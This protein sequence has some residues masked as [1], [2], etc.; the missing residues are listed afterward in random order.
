[1]SLTKSIRK[2]NTYAI[3]GIIAVLGFNT[4]LANGVNALTITRAADGKTITNLALAAGHAVV[5]LEFEEN[6][7]LFS[8]NTTFGAN[9]FPKH[10][11]GLKFNGRD[12][13]RNEVI[14]S[15]DLERNTFL[16]KLASGQTVLL[17]GLN[18]LVGEKS[19]SGAG[20]KSEDFFGYD[21]LLSGAELEKAPV[22][23]EADF[24]EFAALVAP[25]AAAAV[26]V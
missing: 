4:K 10:Q 19:D 17:G 13:L 2:T 18:G 16:A 24:A 26:V 11:L 1:M 8:D 25:A 15:L 14:Q 3:G 7:A 22:V 9:R 5:R 23:P 6:E 21:V 20:A 12:A